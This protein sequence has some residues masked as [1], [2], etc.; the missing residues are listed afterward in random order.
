MLIPSNETI[1]ASTDH[2]ST[3]PDQPNTTEAIATP[4]LDINV[5]RVLSELCDDDSDL[6]VQI[7][8][9]YLCEAPPKLEAIATTVAT[10]QTDAL[11][12]ATH[13][14]KSISQTVGAVKV[15]EVCERL[16]ILGH[17]ESIDAATPV[18]QEIMQQLQHEYTRAAIALNRLKTQ[19][20]S[21]D[22]WWRI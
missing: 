6:L 18:V 9:I 7:I 2:A 14:L 13:S 19:L 5:V 4:V 22:A 21:A 17:Q 11:K 15:A 8:D 3:E 20:H 10:N 16:E 12:Q 1:H